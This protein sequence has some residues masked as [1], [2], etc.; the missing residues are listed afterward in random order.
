M[1]RKKYVEG[2]YFALSL[3]EDEKSL[4]EFSEPYAFGR[5]IG[6]NPSKDM[7]VEIFNY[8][9][10]M[11][12]DIEILKQSGR[13]FQPVSVINYRKNNRWRLLKRDLDYNREIGGYYDVK[14]DMGNL[15]WEGGKTRRMLSE[16]VG[17]YE[18]MIFYV[19]VQ[20]EEKI[21][22]AIK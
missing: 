10:K 20:L 2:D 21:R 14:F 3:C 15:I 9:G 18:K 19:P 11:V 4:S 13:L 5:L 16:E 6:I 1:N 17:K 12:E 22:N 7:I 8:Y